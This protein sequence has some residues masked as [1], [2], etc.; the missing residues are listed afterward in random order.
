ME[1][2]G[3]GKYQSWCMLRALCPIRCR[4][5]WMARD[6]GA[7][8]LKK[9]QGAVIRINILHK[10]VLHRDEHRRNSFRFCSEWFRINAY[11]RRD[12]LNDRHKAKKSW[13]LAHAYLLSPSARCYGMQKDSMLLAPLE[14]T[15]DVAKLLFSCRAL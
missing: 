15:D 5:S 11:G 7:L 6:N 10:V 9:V 13:V 3:S 2:P 14:I 4:L 12:L 1:V 8:H